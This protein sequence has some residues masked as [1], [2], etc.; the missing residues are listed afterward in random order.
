MSKKRNCILT[1]RDFDLLQHLLEQHEEQDGAMMRLLRQKLAAAR[2]VASE[3]LPEDIATLNSRISFQV[4]CGLPETRILSRD[5]MAGAVGILLPV[6]TMRGLALLGLREGEA[7]LLP[8]SAVLVEILR[9]T[10]IHYQPERAERM[11]RAEPTRPRLRILEGRR[12]AG[13]V[14][15]DAVRWPLDEDSGP[16]AT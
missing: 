16:L 3:D 11:R 8:R 14:S 12:N 7:V 1:T 10:A 5:R 13:S 15:P 4:G 6:T 9:L 2:V